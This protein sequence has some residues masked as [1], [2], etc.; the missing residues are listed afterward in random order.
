MKNLVLTLWCKI[1][2]NEEFFK[3]Y[4]IYNRYMLL[5]IL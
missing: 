2:N 5:I 3:K 4:C 1:N